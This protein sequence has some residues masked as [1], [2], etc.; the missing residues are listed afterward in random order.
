MNHPSVRPT[1]LTLGEACV[2]LDPLEDGDVELGMRFQLRVSGSEANMSIALARLGVDARWVSRVAADPMGDLVWRTLLGEGVDLQFASRDPEGF[3][4]LAFKFRRRG[5]VSLVY[6]RRG[7]SAARLQPE[8]LVDAALEGIH[9]LHLTGITPALGSGPRA[10]VRAAAERAKARGIPVTFDLNYR[11]ALWDEPEAAA[12][13]CGEIL[14]FVSWV[15][16]G[17]EEGRRVFGGDDRVDL[18]ARIRASGAGGAIIRVGADG[19]WVSSGDRMVH[20]PG[21]HVDRVIDENG[22]GDA[23]DAGFA[24]GLVRGIDGVKAAGLGNLL[25]ARALA[26][27]GD[28]EML[29]RLA[30]IEADLANLERTGEVESGR[31]ARLG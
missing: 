29:P 8:H 25:G 7:S 24:Y 22:A 23:F 17:L 15:L 4:G 21:V 9:L 10:L 1:V 13:A 3:T 18:A 2:L 30:D 5:V 6:Y 31:V 28:W 16:C 20:V 26:G 27:T 12:L 14:P 19:A 11:P